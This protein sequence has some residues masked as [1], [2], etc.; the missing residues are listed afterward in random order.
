MQIFH[1]LSHWLIY[2][3]HLCDSA[4]QWLQLLLEE[5]DPHAR[6]K[7][8]DWRFHF[9]CFNVILYNGITPIYQV[10]IHYT[11]CYNITN[12]YL[13]CNSI[14]Y[15]YLP[16]IYA[17]FLESIGIKDIKYDISMSNKKIQKYANTQRCFMFLGVLQLEPWVT[18]QLEY[19]DR[20][21]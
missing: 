18:R 2:N 6:F 13:Y 19:M 14:C 1:L 17:T 20:S 8:L 10:W 21:S 15:I 7:F 5:P 11:S 16:N 12:L 3:R 9:I 4:S